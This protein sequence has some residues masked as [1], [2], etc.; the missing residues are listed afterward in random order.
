MLEL[1]QARVELEYKDLATQ[2][3]DNELLTDL[4]NLYIN[5]ESTR[6]TV[7]TKFTKWMSRKKESS[8]APFQKL[9]DLDI[10]SRQMRPVVWG[11]SVRQ[12]FHVYVDKSSSVAKS[13]F[14]KHSEKNIFLVPEFFKKQ[15]NLI[16][17]MEASYDKAVFR[18]SL[19]SNS[20]EWLINELEI[21]NKFR[22]RKLGTVL[23]N[24]L[25]NKIA[26]VWKS[27]PSKESKYLSSSNY[28]HKEEN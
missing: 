10:D 16:W 18:D 4:I 7:A 27:K 19:T 3:I 6:P 23:M 22:P 11:H 26:L 25:E 9:A 13:F 17:L 14:I 15:P 21:E 24:E 1:G 2:K 5:D 12:R 28:F 20:S 8:L